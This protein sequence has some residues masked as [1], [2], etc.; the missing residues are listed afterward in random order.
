VASALA[1]LTKRVIPSL[2]ASVVVGAVV[3]AHGAPLDA[4]VRLAGVIRDVV[5]D[6]DNV[7]VSVFCTVVASAVGVM[8]ASGGLKALVG[9]SERV[10]RG[11][12][13]A[14]AASWLAGLVIFFDD[15]TNC[16]VVGNGLGPLC[17]R[18]G[19]SRAKLAYI[20]D[21]TAAP[22]ASFAVVS[23][24]I[25]FELGLLGDALAS[26]GSPIDALWLFVAALPLR[27]YVLL[28]LVFGLTVAWSG[29]DFG[30]MAAAEAEAH[31][32][33]GSHD[34]AATD[35]SAWW[36]AAVPLGVLLGVTVST[37]AVGGDAIEA[38]LV[39]SFA[40][41]LAAATFSLGATDLAHIGAASWA[42]ARA[43]LGALVV[44]Y[45]AWSLGEFVQQTNGAA[46]LAGQLTGRLPVAL[47]P[48]AVFV[49]ASVTSFATGTSWF[50][51]AALIPLVLPLAVTMGGELAL[52]IVVATTAAV[53]D[54]SIFGDHV[55]PLSD[56]TI[57]SA[58]GSGCDL[59]EHVR[60]QLPYGLVVQAI[61]LLALVPIGYGVPWFVV[62]PAGAALAGAAPFLLGARARTLTA[63]G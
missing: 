49:L 2:A 42:S 38:L 26:A 32:R 48:A 29:R 16:L 12:S 9:L 37:L 8:G 4:A 36:R 51:M 62:L 22:I 45:F 30:P 3:A 5:F 44:L 27:F 13:G 59:L 23:T 11:R 20:A 28:T 1:L 39:G 34:G 47:L 10:A 31:A 63:D 6:L 17:D 40:G 52:P 58:I 54:G 41:W 24:W 61:T 14:Q 7:K 56:T 50:T 57:L 33:R 60:T 53:L 35:V 46:F 19:V 25:G 43:V 21:A 18:H 15:Y 55:S